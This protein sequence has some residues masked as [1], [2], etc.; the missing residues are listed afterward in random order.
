MGVLHV[1]LSTEFKNSPKGRVP[2]NLVFNG[3]S[4]NLKVK[5]PQVLNF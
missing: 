5:N 4:E 3:I 1:P 2:Y